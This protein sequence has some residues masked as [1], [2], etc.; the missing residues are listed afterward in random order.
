MALSVS[1]GCD[2]LALVVIIPDGDIDDV[3]CTTTARFGDDDSLLDSTFVP[4]LP[5]RSE[6]SLVECFTF[7]NHKRSLRA[8]AEQE[9]VI[10]FTRSNYTT[11][12]IN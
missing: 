8:V 5:P 4:I 12:W 7:A 3:H 6:P 2:A 10:C 11:I 9:V 1:G